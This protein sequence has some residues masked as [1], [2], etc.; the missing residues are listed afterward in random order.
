MEALL[1]P[2]TSD[3]ARATWRHIQ[4]DGILHSYRRDN[5]KSYMLFKLLYTTVLKKSIIGSLQ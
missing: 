3:L 1:S 4:E 2:E 5:L